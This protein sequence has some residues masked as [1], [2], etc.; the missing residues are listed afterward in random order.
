MDIIQ[1]IVL[2][3]IQGI[4]EF[5]PISS[6]AHLILPKELLGWPDQGLAFDVAVHVG[7][8]CAVMV[9]FRKDVVALT[10]GWV[11][12]AAGK[13]VNE[14]GRL[15]WLIIAATIPAALFGLLMDDFIETHL[16]SMAVIACTTIVFGILLA[17]A[18][19]KGDAAQKDLLQL[20]L[21]LAIIIG[22]AQAIAL[23]PGTS[24]S[25][26]TITAALF[27][28]F[29]RVDAARFSFLLSIPIIL[30]SGTYKGLGLI[31]ETAVD[32][33]SLITGIVVSAVS[34]YLCIHYFLS[35]INRL[36]M[37]PFV[38]YRLLLGAVLIVMII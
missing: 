31:G 35:F 1:V 20:T 4:T 16:R 8:L 6:S 17:F 37:M 21:T 5:L 9:Y 23:I 13:G 14:D 15:A 19:R 33:T 26:I 18:D 12:S 11:L 38:V 10:T 22:F 7:T 34:A 32:W 29:S 25:G 36:S 2:A 24:R 3:L 28:G 30:M 27:L